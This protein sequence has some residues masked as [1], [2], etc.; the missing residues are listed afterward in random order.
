M[1][2]PKAEVVVLRTAGADVKSVFPSILSIDSLVG[3][4]DILVVKHTDCGALSFRDAKIKQGLATLA[5]N[6][7]AEINSLKFGEI[8][9]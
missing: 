5:P 7:E 4:T 9:G 2:T 6:S 3:F 8:T 1:L